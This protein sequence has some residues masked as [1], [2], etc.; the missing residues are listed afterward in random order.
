MKCLIDSLSGQDTVHPYCDVSLRILMRM[1][2]SL[3]F[4]NECKYLRISEKDSNVIND[5]INF[6]EKHYALKQKQELNYWVD[7][8][9][10]FIENLPPKQLEELE[11]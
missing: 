10:S 4:R 8:P 11:E 9:N 5:L 6:Q 7:L 3:M 2:D 1:A